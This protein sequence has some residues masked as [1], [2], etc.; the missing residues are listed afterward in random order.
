MKSRFLKYIKESR[1]VIKAYPEISSMKIAELKTLDFSD[2]KIK[3]NIIEQPN[4]YKLSKELTIKNMNS[5]FYD[6]EG[7][8]EKKFFDFLKEQ[9]FNKVETIDGN[10]TQNKLSQIAAKD[11]KGFIKFPRL[12]KIRGVLTISDPDNWNNL[13]YIKDQFSSL[14]EV[15]YIELKDYY[16]DLNVILPNVKKFKNILGA[17]KIKNRDKDQIENFE[18]F[19]KKTN[20]QGVSPTDPNLVLSKKNEKIEKA[21][22]ISISDKEITIDNKIF[23]TNLLD[24]QKVFVSNIEKVVFDSKISTYVKI[25]E[26]V[27]KIKILDISNIDSNKFNFFTSS[28]TISFIKEKNISQI[29]FNSYEDVFQFSKLLD[30]KFHGEDFEKKNNNC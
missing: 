15:D 29:I 10:I 23:D 27:G 18:T 6:L 2:K 28:S 17:P 24:V 3:L 4:Q 26:I 20:H 16:A 9:F 5:M 30:I 19:L 21:S 12:S 25:E 14:N 8:N 11:N 22:L 1:D 7:P 13:K